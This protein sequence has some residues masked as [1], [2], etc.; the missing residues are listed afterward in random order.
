MEN[1]LAV[2][3]VTLDDIINQFEAARAEWRSK[4]KSRADLVDDD[5]AHYARL[6]ALKSDLAKEAARQEAVTIAEIQTESRALE[7]EA[8]GR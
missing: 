8:P 1:N 7:A 4:H 3:L 2:L 5:N 6:T